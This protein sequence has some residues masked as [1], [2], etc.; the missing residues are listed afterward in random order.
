MESLKNDMEEL[1]VNMYNNCFDFQRVEAS[2]RVLNLAK[3]DFVNMHERKNSY[4]YLSASGLAEIEKNKFIVASS[5]YDLKN[6]PLVEEESYWKLPS[7]ILEQVLL[8]YKNNRISESDMRWIARNEPWR[9]YWIARKS[10]SSLIGCAPVDM[11]EDQRS[12][13]VWS[14]IYDNVYEHP[15]QPPN[16][17]ISDDDLLDGWFIEQR[18]KKEKDSGAKEVNNMI[19]NSKISNS[20]E[21]FVVANSRDTMKKIASLNNVESDIAKRQR[22]AM[23]DKKGV[24]KESEMPDSKNEIRKK[25]GEMYREKVIQK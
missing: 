12:I 3:Q 11:S 10:E 20:G 22:F 1:K 7:F 14:S 4:N 8:F 16:N 6:N 21:V 15:E 2:R 13:I 5:L 19:G 23:M 18:R 9:S 25:Q 17:V 24:V